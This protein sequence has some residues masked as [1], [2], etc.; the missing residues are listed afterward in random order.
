[1]DYSEPQKALV[2]YNLIWSIYSTELK[3]QPVE[4]GPLL[5]KFID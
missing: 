1:M 4:Y 3:Y 5:L 2:W